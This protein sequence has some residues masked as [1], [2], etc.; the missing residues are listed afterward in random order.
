MCRSDSEPLLQEPLELMDG[1]IDF[2]DFFAR[3]VLVCDVDLDVRV[4][5]HVDVNQRVESAVDVDEFSVSRRRR[6]RVVIKPAILSLL[7]KWHWN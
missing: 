4:R 2:D 5:T 3:F 1:L 7:Q 6:L